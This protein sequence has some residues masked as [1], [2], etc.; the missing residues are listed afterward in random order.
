VALPD[1]GVRGAGALDLRVPVGAAERNRLLDRLRRRR[2]DGLL[3]LRRRV[4]QAPASGN[5]TKL[6]AMSHALASDAARARTPS[7][8]ARRIAPARGGCAMPA[9][10]EGATTVDTN[11]DGNVAAVRMQTTPRPTSDRSVAAPPLPSRIAA[12][13]PAASARAANATRT[14]IPAGSP[15]P[16]VWARNNAIDAAT[17]RNEAGSVNAKR[18]PGRIPGGVALCLRSPGSPAPASGGGSLIA[19]AM[20]TPV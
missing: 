4:C 18:R 13:D 15:W 12:V 1:P 20:R 5:A 10:T 14:V 19:H 8:A 11:A 16:V 9:R 2:R 7:A 6:S 3:H 17:P